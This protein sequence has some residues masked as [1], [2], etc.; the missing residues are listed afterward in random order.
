MK[1]VKMSHKKKNLFSIESWF[2]N[3]DPEIIVYEII[4]H[5]TG[6]V[7]LHPPTKS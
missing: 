5:I 4:P 7:C 3:R 2:F 1:K 6:L